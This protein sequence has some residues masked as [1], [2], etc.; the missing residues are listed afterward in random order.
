MKDLIERLEEA[1]EHLIGAAKHHETIKD[2]VKFL[3]ENKAAIKV[4]NDMLHAARPL[5]H[6][7]LNTDKALKDLK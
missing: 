5:V 1:D 6:S 2:V 4:A 3:K 7:L